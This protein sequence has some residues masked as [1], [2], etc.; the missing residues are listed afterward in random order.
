MPAAPV[1]SHRPHL[2]LC[3]TTVRRIPGIEP[4]IWA[5]TPSDDADREWSVRE[6]ASEPAATRYLARVR[7]VGDDDRTLAMVEASGAT[8]EAAAEALA[9]RLRARGCIWL[10]EAMTARGAA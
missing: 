6:R 2:R 5:S 9:S 7:W 1:P 4:A 8:P 3:G 10:V